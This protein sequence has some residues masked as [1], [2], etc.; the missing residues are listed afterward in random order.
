MLTALLHHKFPL[1]VYWQEDDAR[2]NWHHDDDDDDEVF[3]IGK[4]MVRKRIGEII[5]MVVGT[6]LM[7]G[8]RHRE[9]V[10]Y[11][12]EEAREVRREEFVT[13]MPL[14]R[15]SCCGS[16]RTSFEWRGRV[17]ALRVYS[18]SLPLLVPGLPTEE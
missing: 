5:V 16:R 10:F 12:R 13:L 11:N 17:L 2:E 4:K 7:C 8:R 15:F 3:R 14:L 1:R 9:N 6:D 18:S